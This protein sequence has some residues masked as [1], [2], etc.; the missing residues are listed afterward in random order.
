M[1]ICSEAP[2]AADASAQVLCDMRM[3]GG[4]TVIQSRDG[5]RERPLDFE[6]CWQ[7]YKQGFGDLGGR[8]AVLPVGLWG[9]A[10]HPRAL[11]WGLSFDPHQGHG[12]DARGGGWPEPGRPALQV[13]TGWGWST[14]PASPPS[15]D[16]T[17][18][19]P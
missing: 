15:P 18:S 9:V 12:R 19:S 14:S 1:W 10:R 3:D 8:R 11:S 6:R 7:E 13:I 5:S 2:E 17:R 4:W 16:C